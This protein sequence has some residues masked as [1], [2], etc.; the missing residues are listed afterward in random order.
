MVRNAVR[1]TRFGTVLIVLLAL[2]CLVGC[3]TTF[4]NQAATS[5]PSVSITGPEDGARVGLGDRVTFKAIARALRGIMRVEMRVNDVVTD[6]TTLF[7]ASA[8]FDYEKSWTFNSIGQHRVTVVAYDTAG[9][10]SDPATI[11]VNVVAALPSPTPTAVTPTA[12]PYVVYVTAT[13]LPPSTPT[14]TPYVV[15]VTATRPP[16]PT[17]TATPWRIY[18]TATP[19][20]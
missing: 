5:K 14:W 17:P 9:E 4:S 12:S 8:Q 15:Y 20:R 3:D 16:T 13:P 19:G 18:V 6:N 7:V 2:A 11:V 10:A 1:S